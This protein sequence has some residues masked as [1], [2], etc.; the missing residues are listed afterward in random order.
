M[1][2]AAPAILAGLIALTIAGVMAACGSSDD[3]TSATNSD[4]A[5]ETTEGSADS[6]GGGGALAVGFASPTMQN[7]GAQEFAAALECVAEKTGGSVKVADA[8]VDVNKQISDFESMLTQQLDGITLLAL[9]PRSFAGPL[10]KA[11]KDEIPVVELFNP[12]GE[13]PGLVLQPGEEYGMEAAK[14]ASE[15][16]A[17]ETLKA[18]VLDGPPVPNIAVIIAGFE[19]GAD[20]YGIEIVDSVNAKNSTPDIGRELTEQLLAGN[21]DVNIVFAFDEALAVGAGLAAQGASGEIVTYGVGASEATIDAI[22]QGTVTGTYDVGAYE[23]GIKA[24]EM[25]AELSE[26]GEPAPYTLPVVAYD[27]DNVAE[28][29]PVSERGC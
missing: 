9:D 18:V 10:A 11:A 22:E 20:K 6:S 14:A 8:N 29:Q 25:L 24:W 5:A 4:T 26:G 23:A 13:A 1:R 15:A 3:S 12:E 21:P 19:K 7:P 27:Q 16:L 28:W 17:G 2:R